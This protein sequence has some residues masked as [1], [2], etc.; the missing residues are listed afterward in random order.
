MGVKIFLKKKFRA[1][2]QQ[3]FHNTNAHY[4]EKIMMKKFGYWPGNSLCIWK[5]CIISILMIGLTLLPGINYL[6]TSV[7]RRNSKDFALVVPEVLLEF[8]QTLS[9]INFLVFFKVIK[10]F[11][12]TFE[13]EWN[14]HDEI[15]EWQKLRIKTVKL[16]NRISFINHVNVHVTGLF[17]FT[18]PTIIFVLKYY[19]GLDKNTDKTT[20]ILIE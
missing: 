10:K 19:F 6:V 17:Y 8:Q 1:F 11:Q 15:E 12:E 20:I 14:K 3:F 4:I 9:F 2:V 18:I 13:I 16:C 5:M 7:R